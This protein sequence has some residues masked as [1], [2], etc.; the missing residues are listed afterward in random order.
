VE[1]YIDLSFVR[2]IELQ[3]RNDIGFTSKRGN[4]M[5]IAEKKK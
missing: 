2:E 3:K 4:K 5:R 1:I